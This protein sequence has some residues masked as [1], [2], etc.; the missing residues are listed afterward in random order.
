M[1]EVFE[2][3]VYGRF[4]VLAEGFEGA[5]DAFRDGVGP[6]EVDHV[7][8]DCEAFVF[9]VAA[10]FRRGPFVGVAGEVAVYFR[11]GVEDR[12][13]GTR[14][15]T[16]GGSV[17]GPFLDFGTAGVDAGNEAVAPPF[18]GYLGGGDEGAD[19]A[20]TVHA[21]GKMVR[22][23]EASSFEGSVIVVVLAGLSLWLFDIVF[24]SREIFGQDFHSAF[25]FDN[26]TLPT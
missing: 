22:L 13:D 10:E 16:A 12:G 25:W 15:A 3:G 26:V 24:T 14:A 5:G 6:V 18:L 21:L 2:E 17:G 11:G 19:P 20:E 8:P 1:A 7:V 9:V 4:Y 23:S